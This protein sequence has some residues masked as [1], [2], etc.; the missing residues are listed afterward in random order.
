MEKDTNKKN[1]CA[2]KSLKWGLCACLTALISP[3]ASSMIPILSFVFVPLVIIQ[4]IVGVYYAN[5]AFHFSDILHLPPKA[6]AGMILSV[7]S[8]VIM[9]IAHI[10]FSLFR[11]G[12]F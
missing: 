12:F 5:A 4:E 6:I 7:L 2:K 1:Y 3:L 8:F 10:I 9:I 11:I